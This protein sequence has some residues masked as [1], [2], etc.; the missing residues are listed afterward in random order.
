MKGLFKVVR[1]FCFLVLLWNPPGSCNEGAQLVLSL[2]LRTLG[3]ERP[4]A[5]RDFRAYAFLQDSVVFLDD[6]LLAVSF[7]S[8]N[9]HPG[10]SRR[11]GT[12]GSEVVFQSIFLDPVAGVVSGQRTWGNEGNWNTLHALENGSFLVQDND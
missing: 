11:D 9:D 12:P 7:L 3:Y 5:E 6:R 4:V 10:L 8:K 1:V 2:D